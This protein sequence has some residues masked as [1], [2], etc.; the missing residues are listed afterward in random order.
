MAIV[1][2]E[3]NFDIYEKIFKLIKKNKW[4][5]ILRL[6]QELDV[7]IDINMKDQTGNYIIS[8]AVL[9]NRLD[10]IKILHEKN[11]QLDILDADNRSIL[12]IP[13][14]YGYDEMLE[15][16][17]KINSDIIGVSIIDIKDRNFRTPIHYAILNKNM[18]A[19]KKLLESNCNLN[20][21]DNKGYNAL[22]YSILS[23]DKEIVKLI[24]PGIVNINTRTSTGET[25]L[26]LAVNLQLTDIAEFLIKNGINVNFQD[27]SHEFTA[28]HYAVSINNKYL[29]QLILDVSGNPNIQDIFGNTP[30]HYVMIEETYNL[31]DLFINSK[32]IIC[33]LNLYNIDGKLPL[34]IL[35]DAYSTNISEST[36][37]YLLL[38]SNLAIIDNDGNSCL[39]LLTG[40]G[41]WKSYKTELVKKRLDIY[42]K[43]KKGIMVLDL[44]DK[45]DVDEFIDII[46][47]AYMNRLKNKKKEWD[48]EW[49]NICSKE[50]ISVDQNELKKIFPGKIDSN[51]KLQKIC[52]DKIKEYL[53]ETLEKIKENK[54]KCGESSYPLAKNKTCITLEEGETLDVCTFTGTTL[55]VLL[56]L[57]YLLKK[58]KSA[59]STLS[60][61]FYSNENLQNFYKSIGIMM[62]SR[63]DFL[64]F[65]IV[66]VHQKLYLVDDFYDRI[67]SCIKGGSEFIIIPLG[68]EMKAGSH[69]NYIIYDIKA[70]TVERF[71]PHGSSTPPGLNYEPSILDELIESRFKVINNSIKYFSP[72]DYEPKVGFQLLDIFE[73]N[74]KKIGDPGGFCA[75]WAIWYVDMRLT[76]KNIGCN[77]LTKILIKSIKTQNISVKSMIRN[78]AIN[79]I[80]LR[81]ELFKKVGLD[82]N[83][84]LNDMFTDTQIEKIIE[85]IQHEIS[86]IS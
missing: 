18:F 2:V 31:I 17:L 6:L 25:S 19:I 52:R 60:T 32:K 42:S 66:W 34:H 13:I 49:E 47:D 69:A 51:E 7:E 58:H 4:D 85:L 63:G 84:W 41:L 1:E 68:I 3:D 59:C 10:I 9:H 29:I 75:L 16:L 83:S 14:K 64:N 80:T 35:L 57:I 72:K 61:E 70:N 11:V 46:I 39:F 79:I 22:H 12:Y 20:T 71:E 76:Y 55:D 86:Q 24:L 28:L 45:K 30:L 38:N 26:H 15:Y 82:I 36:F 48:R 23:R 8:Y 43:N 27:Y 56:G 33:N 81:D 62:G 37:K 53:F 74:R 40:L 65:E 54:I 77:E 5:E 67:N 21:S 44:I 73:T 78:Y 50:F